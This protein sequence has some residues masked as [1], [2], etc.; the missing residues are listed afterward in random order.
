MP[1]SPAPPHFRHD[2]QGL[3]ALAV[4]AVVFFHA[5]V[6]L[7]GGFVGVDV[8]FVVSGFVI[9]R[10]LRHELETTGKI[11]LR[12][13]ALRR[14]RRLLPPLAALLVVVVPL[15]LLLGP[16]DAH[17]IGVRT[18]VAASLFNANTYLSMI[19]DGYFATTTE[20]NP[21]LH[22][23]SLSVEEQFYIVLPAALL[24]GWR[25]AMRVGV[26]GV[27]ALRWML[28]AATVV[29][30]VFAELLATGRIRTSIPLGFDELRIDE[31]FAFYSAPSRAWEFAVGALLALG[32]GERLVATRMRSHVVE[33]IGVGGV[34]FTVISY[35][36]HMVFPGLSA[37]LPVVFTAALLLAG[38]TESGSVVQR[39]LARPVMQRLGGLSYSWYLW[40]WPAI[41]FASATFTG[42]RFDTSVTP[43]VFGVGA[44]VPAA[45]SMQLIEN[46]FR[47]GQ[48]SAA[49]TLALGFASVALPIAVAAATVVVSNNVLADR[50]EPFEAAFT[51]SHIQRGCGEVAGLSVDEFEF[52]SFGEE[53]ELTGTA[54]L[55]GDSN[56]AHLSEGFIDGMIAAGVQ[57]HLAAMGGCPFA[58]VELIRGGG[59]VES[60]SAFVERFTEQAIAL[61]P[62]VVVLSSATDRYLRKDTVGLRD[63]SSGQTAATSDDKAITFQAGQ[64]RTI[65]RLQEV[66]IEVVLVRPVPRFL[67]WTPGECSVLRWGHDERGCGAKVSR[68]QAEAQRA[69]AIRTESDLRER[70]VRVV[71]LIDRFCDDESCA[72]YDDAQW[73][74]SDGGHLS[75]LASR[76]LADVFERL[77]SSP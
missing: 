10:L 22:T 57:P 53:S 32:V 20:L 37:G 56:A 16:I 29:S 35:G 52:C 73:W 64:D 46:P 2:V 1:T 55:L 7:P 51:K 5:G 67:D 47:H 77:P 43:L 44:L 13:F 12:T 65:A 71:D 14:V 60:C 21:L 18:G 25:I 36:D 28:G 6:A 76:S 69:S 31:T 19:G 41:V 75:K 72:T 62:D 70:G 26:D 68:A 8:F 49:R 48:R 45:A 58:D 17:A 61:E 34:A 59:H 54:I 3:R 40:H 42:T 11:E 24:V 74:F 9:T 4:I 23:W 27:R 15:S 50:L 66:G 30:L 63:P 33:T 38:G 39:T